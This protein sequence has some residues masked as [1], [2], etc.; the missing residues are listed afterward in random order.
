MILTC[1]KC[2]TSFNLDETLLKATGSKVRCS[3][4]QNIWV[5]FPPE[6]PV[7]GRLDVIRGELG[8]VVELHALAQVER[9]G[10]A[11][12]G[13]LPAVGEIGN[14]GLAAVARIAPGVDDGGIVR[15]AHQVH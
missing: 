8:A 7:E 5:A 6:T 14:D 4:C 10:L 9:V 1:Q 13:D 15:C 11:V 3:L 2:S 12:L